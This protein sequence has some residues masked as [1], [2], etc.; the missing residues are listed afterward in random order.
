LSN[1]VAQ[2]SAQ[3]I[4]ALAGG[5]QGLSL[6][7]QGAQSADAQGSGTQFGMTSHVDQ[8]PAEANASTG[9]AQGQHPSPNAES[10]DSTGI[11]E[12]PQRVSSG[13]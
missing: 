12:V 11:G 8:S 1:I 4:N 10:T 9:N 6:S 2:I 13:R 5:A 3:V 7:S